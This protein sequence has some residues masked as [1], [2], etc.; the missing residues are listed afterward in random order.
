LP[1]T[2]AVKPGGGYETHQYLP[3]LQGIQPY[4]LQFGNG[5]FVYPDPDS[6]YIQLQRRKDYH[7]LAGFTTNIPA[8]CGKRRHQGSHSHTMLIA[9]LTTLISTIFAF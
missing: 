3:V 8:A 5:F 6:D 7:G 9:G 1:C 4:C 2:S